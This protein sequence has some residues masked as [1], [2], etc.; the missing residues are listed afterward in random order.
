MIQS[1][2][3]NAASAASQQIEDAVE[4]GKKPVEQALNVTKEE[5]EKANEAFFNSYDEMSAMNK[6]GADAFIKAG[7][8][9][10]TGAESLGK[11][12]SD[13]VQASA[14]ARVETTKAMMAVS[15][16]EDFVDI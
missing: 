14:E 13:F 9:L 6:I 15:T 5:V 1:N 7:E 4:V 3:T 16:V 12:Y 2:Q 10:T 11:A 8:V